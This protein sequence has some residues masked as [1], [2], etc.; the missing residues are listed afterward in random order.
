MSHQLKAGWAELTLSIISWNALLGAA[1]VSRKV[2]A[3]FAQETGED[4]WKGHTGKTEVHPGITSKDL[5]T[6]PRCSLRWW[7]NPQDLGFQ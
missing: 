4:I 7:L 5:Q 2:T 1:F 3:W 6:L